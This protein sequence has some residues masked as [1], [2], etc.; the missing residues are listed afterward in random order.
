MPKENKRTAG[1]EDPD[2]ALKGPQ[3]GDPITSDEEE[4]VEEPPETGKKKAEPIDPTK[5]L[6]DQI[7]ELRRE[8]L[9]LRTQRDKKEETPKEK[10]KEPEW[11]KALF[12]DP[13]NTIAALRKSIREEI[14]KDL[15]TD[16]QTDQNQRQF[17]NGF[18]ERHPDLRPDR[19]LVEVTMHANMDKLGNLAVEEA[20]DKLAELTRERILRYS[21][22]DDGRKGG[23][24]K[25]LAEGA[26]PPRKAAEQK[27]PE[28]PVTLS[29]I[30]K[31]RRAAHNAPP[32]KRGSAA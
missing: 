13:E 27:K 3:D 31:A 32:G 2:A 17:W 12:E 16:Y 19:D 22:A 28:G 9:Q 4:E 21:G 5:F 23:K 14:T 20:S 10:E 8:M 1:E 29:Q 25:P 7:T 30:I 11:G 26:N 15:R 18:F 24:K 6:T